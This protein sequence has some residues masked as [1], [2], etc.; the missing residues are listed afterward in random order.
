MT[1]STGSA[2]CSSPGPTSDVVRRC[3][4]HLACLFTE[5][6]AVC[7]YRD[8]HPRPI[9][10]CCNLPLFILSIL[11]VPV[12]S[13]LNLKYS[14]EAGLPARGLGGVSCSRRRRRQPWTPSVENSGVQV[15]CPKTP[16]KGKVPSEGSRRVGPTEVPAMRYPP[17]TLPESND[18]RV[19]CDGKKKHHENF[20]GCTRRPWTKPRRG[21][22]PS[23]PARS[24]S[25][26]RSARSRRRPRITRSTRP[27]TCTAPKPFRYAL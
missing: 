7:T 14:R 12:Y 13:Y 21:S 24:R 17:T 3:A 23:S 9:V 15:G 18:R 4:L 1:S 20:T 25:S 16:V 22:C 6:H 10:T 26:P 2:T 11:L 8:H 5:G 27:A 19:A